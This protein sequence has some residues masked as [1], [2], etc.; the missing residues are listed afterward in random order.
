MSPA[1]LLS[2]LGLIFLHSVI[3]LHGL[4]GH[5]KNTW[6]FGR[7]QDEK[8]R[9]K[10]AKILHLKPKTANTVASTSCFWPEDLL[11][12]DFKDVRILTYGY[13]SHVSH[14]FEGGASQATIPA[15]GRSFLNDLEGIRRDQPARPIIFVV[16]SLGGLVLKDALRRS[17]RADASEADLKTVYDST[18]AIIFMGT[19]HRGSDYAPW[20][21]IARN[22]AVAAGF[23]ANDRLL[24]DL[25]ADST[26]LDLLRDEFGKMLREEKFRV[27]TF[28]EGKGLKGVQG[29]TT[30]VVGDE[31]SALND[32]KERRDIINAN[33]MEMCRFSGAKDSGYRKVKNALAQCL[34][35]LRTIPNETPTQSTLAMSQ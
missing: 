2:H 27:Y 22:I 9:G 26:M 34:T 13:D 31:S 35:L 18:K 10:L 29:L 4:Q 20:G 32:G 3:F 17:W 25:R 8:E 1:T 24:K 11:P 7:T 23:D 16:H 21:I 6:T 5:P 12:V 28:S 33:H 14:F 19:P 30:K 15:L